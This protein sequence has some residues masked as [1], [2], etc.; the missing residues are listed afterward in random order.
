MIQ[1]NAQLF[2]SHK[3]KTSM[4]KKFTLVLSTV[5]LITMAVDLNYQT[6]TSNPNAA[7]AGN[8][9]S[10][11]DGGNTCARSGCHTGGPMASNQMVTLEGIPSSG[12]IG[13][14]TYNMT[15]TM[16]NGGNKFGFSLSP[17]T[18]AGDLVGSLTASGA[19]TTLNGNLKYLTHTQSGTT[20]SGTKTYTFD[21]T[22]PT[23]GTGDVMFYGAFNF[24]NGNGGTSGD[25]ILSETFSFNE[26]T[27]GISEAELESLSVYPNPV[28]DEI[29]IAAKDV[30]EEIMITLFDV[31]GRKV[32]EERHAGGDIKIDIKSRSLNTGIYFLQMEVDGKST[33]KKMLIK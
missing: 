24:A 26:A 9:G 20:G 23:S 33:I 13:G 16:S 1:G 15:I 11:G 28:I 8:T 4:K 6:V 29:H 32:L 18:T 17:Q 2:L 25:V 10:P 30:D 27:V 3:K 31:Q 21:W 14:Q 22:A 12:Y 5:L 7:P 19:G